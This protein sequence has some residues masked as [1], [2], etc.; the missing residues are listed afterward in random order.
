LEVVKIGDEESGK[1]FSISR[2]DNFGNDKERKRV[3]YS[4]GSMLW[5]LRKRIDEV[6]EMELELRAPRKCSNCS[7]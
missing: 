5:V 1:K 3:R 7:G 2:F 4:P 6:T